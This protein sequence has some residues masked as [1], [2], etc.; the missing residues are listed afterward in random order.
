[1]KDFLCQFTNIIANNVVQP[2]MKSG[3]SAR[4]MTRFHV[5]IVTARIRNEA[6]LIAFLTQIPPTQVTATRVDVEIARVIP[7]LPVITDQCDIFSIITSKYPLG[8]LSLFVILVK[9]FQLSGG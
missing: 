2:L 9:L 5:K 6:Y 3:Q 1:M 4:L 8:H 7:V